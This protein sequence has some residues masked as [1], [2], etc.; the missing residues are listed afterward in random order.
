MTLVSQASGESAHQISKVVAP[1]ARAAALLLA[2]ASHAE[3]GADLA[4]C[5]GMLG[6]PAEIVQ[7]C[8]IA[9]ESG[10]LTEAQLARALNNRCAAQVAL[11]R[12]DQAI[13]DCDRAL[14]LDASLSA[15]LVNRGNARDYQG[16]H[17][18]AIADY[19]QAIALRPAFAEAWYNRAS[20]YANKRDY[21]RAIADYG[22]ALRLKPDFDRALYDRARA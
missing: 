3:E 9:I 12:H 13:A 1:L 5:E 6:S 8:G 20:A 22:E 21:A 16:A 18:R 11:G 7:S 14:A 17:D 4:V 2:A 10:A 19:D 15:A